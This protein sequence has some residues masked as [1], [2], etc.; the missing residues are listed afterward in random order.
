[1][2]Q[3]V[4]E[5]IVTTSEVASEY[6]EILPDWVKIEAVQDKYRQRILEIQVDKGEASALAL[7]LESP[8]SL[9]IID[10]YR[11]RK[12]AGKLKINYTGTIGV[13]VK[14]KLT[15]IILSVKPL[16]SKIAETNFRV[17]PEIEQQALKEAGE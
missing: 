16:L 10:D 17:S 9:I 1:M 15:G 7:A 11:A 5:Q 14:A 12:V 13:I 8:N 2:L 6:G 4:Y 3:K